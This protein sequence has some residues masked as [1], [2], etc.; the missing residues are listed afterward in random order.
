MNSTADL[1]DVALGIFHRTLA[2]IDVESVVPAFV[3]LDGDYGE[4]GGAGVDVSQ[5]ERVIVI[6]I[7]KASVPMA[8]AFEKV[9]N[10]RISDGLVATNAVIRQSP[11]I[12]P[13]VVGGHPLP[14]S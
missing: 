5:F 10:D 13:V 9:L 6:A 12:L 4:I 7:G 3:R 2:A 1:R 14:N 8:R 11:R